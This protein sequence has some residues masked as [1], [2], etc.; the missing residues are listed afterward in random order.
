[1]RARA[2]ILAPVTVVTALAFMACTAKPENS[3]VIRKKFA[4]V[5]NMNQKVTE[6]RTTLDSVSA[7]LRILNEQIA[8]VR[9]LNP[10]TANGTD[11]IKRIEAL[12]TRMKG[13]SQPTLATNPGG[14][15]PSRSQDPANGPAALAS[16]ANPEPTTLNAKLAVPAEPPV[17]KVSN[18]I[19]ASAPKAEKAA[20]TKAA[21]ATETSAKPQKAA[22]ETVKKAA[23][24]SAGRYYRVQ[25]GD[26]IDTIAARNGISVDS[27]RKANK[28]PVGSK[29][30]AG[31][32]LYLPGKG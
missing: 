6:M 12:E 8:E 31:Q 24:H 2:F 23:T 29:V 9:A 13:G 10:D 3:P 1:M 20:T 32:N 27:I 16:T 25:P 15:P 30:P 19:V 17:K 4:E 5:D 22:A 21:K 14:A 11:I 26:T 7:D 28:L 18:D